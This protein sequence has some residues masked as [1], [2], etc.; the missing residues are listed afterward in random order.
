[1]ALVLQAQLAAKA[2]EEIRTEVDIDN[3]EETATKAMNEAYSK[4]PPVVCFT[5]VGPIVKVWLTYYGYSNLQRRYVRVGSRI[6]VSL[7]IVANDCSKWRVFGAL[8][9]N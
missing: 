9:C 2:M 5:C 7:L 3:V 6:L 1:V 8:L 4:L